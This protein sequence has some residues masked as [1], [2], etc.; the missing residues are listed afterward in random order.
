M[1]DSAPHNMIVD[2]DPA[3]KEAHTTALRGT[4]VVHGAASGDELCAVLERHPVAAIIL[5]VML[6]N[7]CGLDLIGRFRS[8]SQAQI[9]ALTGYG[10]EEVAVRALRAG[11]ERLSSEALQSGSADSLTPPAGSLGGEP[12]GPVAQANRDSHR[13]VKLVRVGLGDRV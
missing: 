5:D 12:P 2:D 10:S 7:E 1:R 8:L 3:I 11:G 4:Y 6:G 9:L 13:K